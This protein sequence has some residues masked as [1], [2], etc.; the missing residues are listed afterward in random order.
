MGAT[1]VLASVPDYIHNDKISPDIDKLDANLRDLVLLTAYEIAPR[2]GDIQQI[3]LITSESHPHGWL[4]QHTRSTLKPIVNHPRL[5]TKISGV[6][7][8]TLKAVDLDKGRITITGIDKDIKSLYCYYD[9]IDKI[10]DG[11]NK[12]VEVQGEYEISSNG[13]PCMMKVDELSIISQPR[14]F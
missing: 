4:T 12:H 11:L 13:K 1:E 10:R 3:R 14:I 6:F 5:N 2:S 7:S 9:N 8:G